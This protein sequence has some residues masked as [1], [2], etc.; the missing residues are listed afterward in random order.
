MDCKK[1]YFNYACQAGILKPISNVSDSYMPKGC[2][3][4][5]SS[6]EITARTGEIIGI[7]F[8]SKPLFSS[9]DDTI[10]LDDYYFDLSFKKYKLLIKEILS[11]I[12]RFHNGT[13]K[14][15]FISID[16]FI[17]LD[18]MTVNLINKLNLELRNSRSNISL[19]VDKTSEL[20][21]PYVREVEYQLK[22]NEI[23]LG[24]RGCFNKKY[25]NK[26]LLFYEYAFV[27]T[28]F[29]ES[30]IMSQDLYSEFLDTLYFLTEN[31]VKLILEYSNDPDLHISLPFSGFKHFDN[32]LS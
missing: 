32:K 18:S 31:G 20:I 21:N 4:W 13:G 8:T 27:D 16:E 29:V 22:D 25:I 26:D 14:N 10:F 23:S 28:C 17:L 9:F 12:D 7:S 15:Y 30:R 1:C 11:K 19:I 5:H 6:Q 2:N 24:V 3:Y